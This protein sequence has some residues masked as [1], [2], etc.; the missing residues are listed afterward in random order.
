MGWF[1]KKTFVKDGK[2]KWKLVKSGLEKAP[3][4]V[5]RWEQSLRLEKNSS[6]GERTFLN[7][8]ETKT[9]INRKVVQARTYFGRNKKVVRDLITTS[10]S[11]PKHYERKKWND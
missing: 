8:A 4:D 3:T 7:F 10:N 11:I 1:E 6:L 9:G 5:G 2:G